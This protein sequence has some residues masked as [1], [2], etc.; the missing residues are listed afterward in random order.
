MRLPYLPLLAFA[1]L[2]VS[3]P[4][5]AQVAHGEVRFQAHDVADYPGGYAVDIADMDNDGDLDV[6]PNSVGRPGLYWFEN[7]SWTRHEIVGEDVSRIVN[8]AMADL[9]G[10]GIPEVAIQSEFAMQAANSDGIN[11]IAE[12]GGTPEGSWETMELDR[13]PTSHHVLFAD[14]DGNG[15]LEMVNAPLIGPGSLA[16]TYDADYASVFWYSPDGAE[17]GLI[18]DANIPGVI[19]R[20]RTVK[21]DGDDRD[22]I[23]V[24]SF[25]GIGLYRAQGSGADMTFRKDLISRGYVSELAPRL[26]ASDVGVGPS[27]TSRIVASVEP[28]HGNEVV[29]YTPNGTEWARRVIFD[30]IG[31]GHEVWVADLNNDGYSDIIANDNSRPNEQNPDP[32]R[33]VHVFFSP[34]NP[35]TG[36]WIYRQIEREAGMN[37]CVGGDMNGDGWTDLV[38]TGS[39]GVVRWYENLGARRPVS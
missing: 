28:W 5:T 38:C 14:L 24:A 36:Q 15:D 34:E 12:S 10:D 16:P 31:S 3:Q 6:V 7:P 13:F 1:A 4:A 11:W 20:I 37:G 39:G 19:H 25:E 32:T 29:V 9:D 26:G 35:A 8:K 22:A 30:Q 23:L 21:W 27:G 17:R 33:G 2:T 18:A